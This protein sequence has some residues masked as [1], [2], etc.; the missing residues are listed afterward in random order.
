MNDTEL[1]DLCKEVYKRTEWDS[2]RD[3]YEF[4]K[5]V[6]GHLQLNRANVFAEAV[7]KDR[8]C[9]LYTVEYI[10][11]KLPRK[12]G[13]HVLTVQPVSYPQWCASYDSPED[14]VYNRFADTPLK[15]LLELV[16]ALDEVGELK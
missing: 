9:P 12:I 11:E 4:Y 2:T 13:Q 6:S 16:I 7:P 5:D 1:F 8:M 3:V 10:L 15:A 14:E